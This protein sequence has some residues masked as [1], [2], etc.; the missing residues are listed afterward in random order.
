MLSKN[1]DIERFVKIYDDLISEKKIKSTKLYEKS[2]NN[3]K[4]LKVVSKK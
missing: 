1:E 4:K 2:K 3:I